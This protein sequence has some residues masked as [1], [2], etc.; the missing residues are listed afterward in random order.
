MHRTYTKLNRVNRIAQRAV[1]ENTRW[2]LRTARYAIA[3]VPEVTCAQQ[4]VM[5]EVYRKR[6][7]TIGCACLDYRR[8]VWEDRYRIVGRIR[9]SVEVRRNQPNHITCVIG[10]VHRKRML[11]VGD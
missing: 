7:T 8:W 1:R 11:R 10:G 2:S 9:T 6:S 5:T 4:G 3:Q